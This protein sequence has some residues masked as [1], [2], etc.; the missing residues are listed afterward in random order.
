MSGSY[1]HCIHIIIA[2]T[3]L[4]LYSYNNYSHQPYLCKFVQMSACN[5]GCSQLCV[6]KP[7]LWAETRK[8]SPRH[9]L[10]ALSITIN[11]RVIYILNVSMFYSTQLL[12]LFKINMKPFMPAVGILWTTSLLGC[13][14]IFKKGLKW[15]SSETLW[16]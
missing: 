15:L 14:L 3:I 7:Q 4:T 13:V 9:I 8:E 2:R 12:H 10:W 16:Y 6:D 5:F 1:S 11:K